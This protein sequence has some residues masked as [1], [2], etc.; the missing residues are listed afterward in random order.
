MSWIKKIKEFISPPAKQGMPLWH[1]KPHEI[2][3]ELNFFKDTFR[4]GI[5]ALHTNQADHDLILQYKKEL[6]NLGYEAEVLLFVDQKEMPRY[7]YLPTVSWPDLNKQR[8]P[9]SPRT[10]RYC[11]KRFDL[12][13]N[14]FFEDSGPLLYLA[15]KS[16]AK[17]RIGAYRPHLKEASDVFVYSEEENDLAKL[18]KAIDNTLQK[19]KYAHKSY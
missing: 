7:V 12:L 15:S 19:Q 9:Y 17:C 16:L 1:T 3:R 2:E 6:E 11:K 10:D 8:I 5:L 13:F 4:I 14:L 18:I